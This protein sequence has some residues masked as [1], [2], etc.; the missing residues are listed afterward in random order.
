MSAAPTQ[1]NWAIIP[2]SQVNFG[3][4]SAASAL[5]QRSDYYYLL[6]FE[7]VSRVLELAEQLKA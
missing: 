1:D 4:R 6:R 7:S 3:V 5:A 2:G